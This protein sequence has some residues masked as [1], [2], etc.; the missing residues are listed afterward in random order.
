MIQQEKSGEA[1]DRLSMKKVVSMILALDA[2][3][4]QF[5]GRTVYHLDFEP[6]YLSTSRTFYSLEGV[7]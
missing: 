1:I 4:D 2:Q 3:S 5:E 6:D 7:S